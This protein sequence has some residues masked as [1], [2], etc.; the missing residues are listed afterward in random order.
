MGKPQLQ[1][2]QPAH[3]LAHAHTTLREASE[4]PL[5]VA[6]HKPARELERSILPTLM[7]LTGS[8]IADEHEISHVVARLDLEMRHALMSVMSREKLGPTVYAHARRRGLVGLLETL[9]GE[10]LQAEHDRNALSF[11]QQAHALA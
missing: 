3:R 10:M 2:A 5:V 1:H 11:F 6:G 7:L 4:N 9:D 8:R